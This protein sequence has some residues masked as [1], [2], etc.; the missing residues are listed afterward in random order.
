[1]DRSS[2]DVNDVSV[3]ESLRFRTV[4]AVHTNAIGLRFRM[5][6]FSMKTISVFD[7]VCVDR[8]PKRIE[9]YAKCMRFSTH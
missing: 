7:R 9:M 4:F 2:R 6:A 5:Y 8:R 3:F 1:M